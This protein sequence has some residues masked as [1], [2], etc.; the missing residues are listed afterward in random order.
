MPI[1]IDEVVG[2]VEPETAHPR[3]EAAEPETS[4]FEAE[5]LRHELRCLEKRAARLRAD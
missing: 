4:A 3:E 2:E 5:R 1:A